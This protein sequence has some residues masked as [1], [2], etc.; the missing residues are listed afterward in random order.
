[1][2]VVKPSVSHERNKRRRRIKE[3]HRRAVRMGT[4]APQ[5]P[6]PGPASLPPLD[7]NF[8]PQ[9]WSHTFPITPALPRTDPV[10]CRIMSWAIQGR[11]GATGDTIYSGIQQFLTHV[12]DLMLQHKVNIMWLTDARFTAGTLDIYLPI[13]HALLPNC[14]VIQFPTYFIKTG[15]RCQSFNRMGGAV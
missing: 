5:R 1:M 6:T 13:L 2:R 14:R 10:I 3:A 15:S 8:L 7:P 9:T 4:A 11:L 12:A